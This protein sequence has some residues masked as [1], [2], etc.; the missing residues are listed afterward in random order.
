MSDNI[1][2]DCQHCDRHAMRANRLRW[3]MRSLLLV[4]ALVGC[5]S[6]QP[7]CRVVGTR[8]G[9]APRFLRG[10]VSL[11]ELPGNQILALWTSAMWEIPDAGVEVGDMGADGGAANVPQLHW[12]AEIAIF[13]GTGTVHDRRSIEIARGAQNIALLGDAA[14]VATIARTMVT[15]ADGTLHERTAVSWEID[16]PGSRGPL[17]EVAASVCLDCYSEVSFAVRSVGDRAFVLF[18]RDFTNTTAYVGITDSGEVVAMGTVAGTL[19]DNPA[20]DALLFSDQRGFLF[21]TDR[22]GNPLGPP[23]DLAAASW[24]LSGDDIV[25]LAE[26]RDTVTNLDSLIPRRFTLD[27]TLRWEGPRIST[28]RHV[29]ALH[30]TSEGGLAVAFNDF[31]GDYDTDYFAMVDGEGKKVGGDLALQYLGPYQGRLLLE[32]APRHFVLAYSGPEAEN[33]VQL[34][35]VQ[36]DP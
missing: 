2:S 25:G 5:D 4:L 6:Y 16:R 24:S 23:V 17:N 28:A 35:S 1:E 12:T 18:S 34:L 29:E 26:L 21:L 3:P 7:P 14:L 33:Q 31:N 15:S 27:G 11:R 8:S 9:V 32:I 22:D 30:A 36:C 13:D 20:S 19:V 10:D